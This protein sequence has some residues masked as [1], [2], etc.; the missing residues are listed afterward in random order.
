MRLNVEYD[1]IQNDRLDLFAVG[2]SVAIFRSEGIPVGS[3][4]DVIQDG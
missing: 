4:Y 2:F 1:L 3:G